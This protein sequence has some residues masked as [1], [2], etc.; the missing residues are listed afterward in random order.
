VELSGNDWHSHLVLGGRQ[1]D[2]PRHSKTF[3][4]KRCGFCRDGLLYL[5]IAVGFTFRDRRIQCCAKRLKPRF[6]LFD[7]PKPSRT[8]S[9]AE[10]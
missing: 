4:S 2:E 6:A 1:I 3:V 10:P 9:L 7:Q 8:T 5:V